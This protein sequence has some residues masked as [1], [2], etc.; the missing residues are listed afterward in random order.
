[1]GIIAR[2]IL[3][4]FRPEV[5][6]GIKF[7]IFLWKRR[8]RHVLSPMAENFE[9]QQYIQWIR[10]CCYITVDSVTTA[11]QNGASTYQCIS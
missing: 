5:T 3:F 6:T 7:L 9:I 4:N 11:L 2:K 10:R 8:V 1:M